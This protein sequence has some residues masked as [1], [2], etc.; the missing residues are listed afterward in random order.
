V[1]V[2]E[3]VELVVAALVGGT[4][5]G[6][7]NATSAAVSDAYDALK[8]LARKALLR[9]AGHGDAGVGVEVEEKLADPLV[10]RAELAA[11]LSAAGAEA[12]AELVAAARR[13]L[14]LIDP[15]GAAAGKYHVVLRGNKGVQVGDHNTQ[16]IHFGDA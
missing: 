11:A 15:Q 6:V 12:D 5:A 4:A 7:S 14:S 8:S 9:G 1:C 3:S 2:I 10:H 13:L 16:T